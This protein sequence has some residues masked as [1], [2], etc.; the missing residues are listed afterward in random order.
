MNEKIALVTNVL[1]FVGPPAVK[2][3]LEGEYHVI[4]QDPAFQNKEK[5]E[6]YAAN[7]AGAVP[8]GLREPKELIRQVWDH[9]KRVDVIVS[10]DTYPAIHTPIAEAN[11]VA[12]SQQHI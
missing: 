8:I 7:N 10:N 2:A 9:H 11:N 1:D 6:A 3:L 12:G 4:A 5:L